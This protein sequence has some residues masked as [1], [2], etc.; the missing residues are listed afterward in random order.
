[1]RPEDILLTDSEGLPA[2]VISS[3]FL[4]HAV[5][6]KLQTIDGTRAAVILPARSQV[7]ATGSSVFLTWSDSAAHVLDD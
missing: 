3:E 7:P 4:G 2:T 1:V 5:R 6:L